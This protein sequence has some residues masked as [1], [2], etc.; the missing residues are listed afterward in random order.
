MVQMKPETIIRRAAERT[1]KAVARRAELIRRLR[2][3]MDATDPRCIYREM[4]AEMGLAV[5]LTPKRRPIPR[6][7]TLDWA[8]FGDDQVARH[9]G[10]LYRI[11]PAAGTGYDLRIVHETG[12][13]MPTIPEFTPNAAGNEWVSHFGVALAAA[14]AMANK[15]SADM[16][17]EFIG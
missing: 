13:M 3:K 7:T 8:H 1:A 5:K 11:R 17:R 16:K 14:Q 9:G 2:E 10:L 6:T 12:P 15:R 4:L